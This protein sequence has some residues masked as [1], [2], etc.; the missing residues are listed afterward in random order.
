MY[1]YIFIYKIQ[2]MYPPGYY[3]FTNGLMTTQVLRLMVYGIY[4]CSQRKTDNTLQ[5]SPGY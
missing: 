3:H 1:I 2:T 5:C 4:I